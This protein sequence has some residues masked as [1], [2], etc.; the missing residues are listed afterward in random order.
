MVDEVQVW[1]EEGY[2]VW[3]GHLGGVI[4]R[5]DGKRRW[6]PLNLKNV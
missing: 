1:V 6:P 3:E 5:M 4:Q 2:G